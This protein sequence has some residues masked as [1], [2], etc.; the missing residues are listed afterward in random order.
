MKK[1]LEPL[2]SLQKCGLKAAVVSIGH[3]P[4]LEAELKNLTQQGLFDKG[5]YQEYVTR[6]SF[7]VPKSLPN[8]QSII[9][10]AVQMGQSKITLNWQG[11]RKTLVIPP[12]YAWFERV[13]VQLEKKVG[14]TLNQQGYVWT[15]PALPLKLL[16]AQSGL[17]QY[18][19]NN[20][21][22]V[23]GM[24]S[25]VRFVAVYSDM[26]CEQDNWQKPQMMKACA[27]CSLCCQACPTGAIPKDRFLLY[28]ER[29]LTYHNE[30]KGDIPFPNWINPAWHNSVIGCSR[31][32]TVCPQ[33]RTFLNKFN[34]EEEFSEQ[35]TDQFL[36]GTP[37]EKMQKET[38]EKLDRLGLAEET[39]LLPRNLG[40]FFK[41]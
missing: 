36:K 11:Q 15:R 41:Q 29:C 28:A 8:V 34:A 3:L 12:I 40:V 24:G 1:T 27:D 37:K 21:C 19:K 33:N 6:F 22:Y 18:G 2:S 38:I 14:D 32:Q 5:F 20:I 31:C 10:G 13:R 16:A 17:A 35:E 39:H 30:K 4:E 25:F 26:P 9:V 23:E 7:S